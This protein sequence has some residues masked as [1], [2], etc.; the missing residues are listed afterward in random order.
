MDE[1][2]LVPRALVVGK[3]IVECGEGDIGW[4][5]VGASEPFIV[6]ESLS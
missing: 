6:V 1:E 5:D 2:D 4:L 3:A